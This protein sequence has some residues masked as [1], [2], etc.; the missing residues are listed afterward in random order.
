MI[1]IATPD[2]RLVG[3][4]EDAGSGRVHAFRGVQ[5]AT[6]A[7][8]GPPQRVMTWK[9]TRDATVFGPAAPQPVG[10]PLD[11]LVP[12]AFAGATDEHACLTLNVWVPA[13]SASTARAVLVW[14]PG[15]AFTIALSESERV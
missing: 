12:G 1:E 9:G 4:V 15:G 10:G 13:T 8:F 7:R 11:G 3:T 2:G 5:Y 14:F 6:A